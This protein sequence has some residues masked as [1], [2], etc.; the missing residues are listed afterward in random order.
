MDTVQNLQDIY[1]KL[2][3][4]LQQSRKTPSDTDLVV[5]CLSF[6]V[7]KKEKEYNVGIELDFSLSPKPAKEEDPNKIA[8]QR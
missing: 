3:E 1:K 6:N 8:V 2:S 7:G 5:N 4:Y